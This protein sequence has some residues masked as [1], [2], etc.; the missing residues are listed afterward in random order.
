M[1]LFKPF[2]YLISDKNSV[3]RIVARYNEKISSLTKVESMVLRNYLKSLHQVFRPGLVSISW[4]SLLVS[5]FVEE[6]E[7][8]LCKFEMKVCEVRKNSLEME[9]HVMA[10]AKGSLI[11]AGMFS[12]GS[13]G[14]SDMSD[15]D[16]AEV[17]E[18]QC[19]ERT[20]AFV[21]HYR[22]LYPLLLNIEMSVS[23]S[24]SGMVIILKNYYEYWEK[25]VFNALVEALFRSIMI[26]VNAIS[27]R[28]GAAI[29][30]VY[31]GLK[32]GSLTLETTPSTLDITK[33]FK[34]CI[35]CIL[36]APKSI[37][38]WKRGTCIEASRKIFLDN[39]GNENC[40][41]YSF[42]DD[43]AQH[44]IIVSA[45]FRM[46]DELKTMLQ[47]LDTS[48]CEWSRFAAEK[49]IMNQK[50]K[51]Q[52][53][54]LL[55]CSPSCE[56][57]DVKLIEYRE[58]GYAI[59][60]ISDAALR[61]RHKLPQLRIRAGLLNISF[62][63]LAKQLLS[64][65]NRG[66]ADFT[67][68]LH[69]MGQRQLGSITDQIEHCQRSLEKHPC[70]LNDLILI[71]GCI[72]DIANQNMT[73]ESSIA[74]VIE[75][76]SILQAHEASISP[77][78]IHVVRTL[79]DSWYELFVSSKTKDIRLSK[80]KDHY[81]AITYKE[82]N[83]FVG[84]LAKER[85]EFESNGPGSS[86]VSLDD[87]LVLIDVWIRKLTAIEDRKASLSIAETLLGL[88]HKE[89]IDLSILKEEISGLQLI[90]TVYN[91]FRKALQKKSKIL[92]D[93]IIVEDLQHMVS[94]FE[95]KSRGL[96]SCRKTHAF[97]ALDTY[98]KQ[99][100]ASLSVIVLLK[101]HSLGN[102]HWEKLK[103]LSGVDSNHSDHLSLRDVL[104]MQLG[105]KPQEVASVINEANQEA[106]ISKEL[107]TIAQFW[108]EAEFDVKDLG[109]DGYI[110][111]SPG[112]LRTSL[113]DHLLNIQAI[114]G[115]RFVDG[116]SSDVQH[117][118]RTLH[119]IN[120]CIEIWYLVQQ[121]Q[122]YLRNIFCGSDDIRSQLPQEVTSFDKA[123]RIFT[124]LMKETASN[125]NVVQSCCVVGRLDT[126]TELSHQFDHCQKRLSNYL[127][128]KRNI[129]PRFYF[130][131]D[132]ELLELLGT[133]SNPQ[134]INIHIVKIM[135]NVQNVTFDNNI[136]IGI[137]S[138]EGEC[139]QF[140]DPVLCIGSTEC[141][142][143]LIEEEIRKSLWTYTKTAIYNYAEIEWNK[144]LSSKCTLG[145][146]SIVST[147]IWWTWKVEDA[148]KAINNSDKH[149][150]QR[151]ENC[152]ESDLSSLVA[153][154]RS[155]LDAITRKKI[156]TLLIIDVH[157][158][159]IVSSFIRESIVEVNEFEW[160]S[161]LRFYWN[162]D[163]DDIDIR[164]CT[165]NFC[166][167]YEYLGL[168]SRLVITPLTDRCYMTLTQALTFN[169]G[170]SP[171]GP[172]GTGKVSVIH[173]TSK[174]KKIQFL[175]HLHID[176]DCER[177]GEI[178]CSCVLCHQLWG[179]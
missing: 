144:W 101:K 138:S 25:R 34:R 150:L 60:N 15:I 103:K 46:D 100:K 108:S 156:N 16:V 28:E 42:Y 9:E 145:M 30:N 58:L 135:E 104:E 117:W 110:L 160:E 130:I 43:I 39:D 47:N 126:L 136:A 167:G 81:R 69:T 27:N 76:Y 154:V 65:I 161:Q 102:S 120:E 149:A 29:L 54:K 176:R 4:N 38:R 53:D 147:Q 99:S 12:P 121:K 155:P 86:Y 21:F 85:N 91:D 13:N 162:K 74:R 82:V 87:G 123:I 142:M 163:D 131:S 114:G 2:I 158:K 1:I 134:S 66:K 164:Q 119:T 157:S 48:C 133:S 105:E 18:K 52:L 40:I 169:M 70:S 107:N 146:N 33:Y 75:I 73:M 5:K 168:S 177:L 22:Q 151:L 62:N 166:Y 57:F 7:Q 165:G 24:N 44:S 106:K 174:V 95:T 175:C 26:L 14:S 92:W 112:D 61:Q 148:F 98:V 141:W 80:E 94:Q 116:F 125:S 64:H 84:E 118:E 171:A 51:N 159:D 19:K 20:V 23:E 35:Q 122:L 59:C 6:C 170:G 10:I 77:D 173:S 127:N 137:K 140:R 11:D 8:A 96:I 89:F 3:E 111:L 152:L 50:Q 79:S 49:C 88:S 32:L 129:Y 71:I 97:K 113:E 41:L 56:V 178:S 115:S 109:K 78:E 132:D 45:L 124:S 37:I 63:S 139:V 143:T 67:E 55:E 17:I 172:A 36:D 68:A 83:A 31:I 128:S 72:N 179:R 90:Y 93:E 153:L